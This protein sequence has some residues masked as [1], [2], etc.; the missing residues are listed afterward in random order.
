MPCR[1][2]VRLIWVSLAFG[3]AVMEGVGDEPQYHPPW[4]SCKVVGVQVGE[5]VTVWL[6]EVKAKFL[7]PAELPL[8]TVIG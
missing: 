8:L 3:T 2:T 4:G 1:S 6:G 7:S 5:G